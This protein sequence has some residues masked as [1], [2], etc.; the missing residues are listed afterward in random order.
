MGSSGSITS[1]EP[2][3]QECLALVGDDE[4]GLEVAQ[5]L[6]GAPVLGEF[7]GRAI[8]IAGILL[9]LGLKARETG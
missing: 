9:E 5:H 7:D 4:Q 1:P 3:M 6:V 8:Q 2:E